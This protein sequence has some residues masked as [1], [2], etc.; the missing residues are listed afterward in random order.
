MSQHPHSAG[1]IQGQ[2]SLSLPLLHPHQLPHHTAQQAAR[3]LR[4]QPEE[5]EDVP[6]E[7]ELDRLRP[8]VEDLEEDERLRG[9]QLVGVQQE[10]DVVIPRI[11]HHLHAVSPKKQ[12]QEGVS[13]P[14]VRLRFSGEEGEKNILDLA[15]I[16][17]QP[18]CPQF[19]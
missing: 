18:P 19:V 12:P 4:L 3:L 8:A 15:L 16:F 17:L 9:G 13:V 6:P 11:L 1:N 5:A 10:E 7:A 14:T 2:Q